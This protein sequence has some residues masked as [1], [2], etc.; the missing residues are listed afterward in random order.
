[1]FESLTSKGYQVEFTS[2]AEAILSVD[3]STA[4]ADLEKALLATT[5]PIEEII[6]SGGG[7]AKG[8]QRL[9]RV[10]TQMHWIKGTFTVQKVINGV[11]KESQSHIVDHVKTFEN[12]KTLALEIEWNNKDPFFDR[13]LE[14]Y[15]R[16]HADGAIS[17]G[18]IITRGQSLQD[19]MAEMVRRFVVERQVHDIA[20]MDEWGYS[21]TPKQR[22]RIMDAI[23]RARD[24][25][26]FRDAFA[27][28]FTSDKFGQ[29]TTHWRKLEDRIHRG[30]GNPCPMVYI[31]LPDSIVTFG[32]GKAALAEIEAGAAA[33]EASETP[34]D[35]GS[36]K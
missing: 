14:N 33:D 30:V 15:K 22:K 36:A 9:R 19:N 34:E 32:E 27:S 21:P 28:I 17:V 6:A 16:F 35:D 10:L 13:D 26:S 2:H 3:F 4:A 24:P 11:A 12:G 20:G 23:T 29:A 7:E 31:G 8:T 25:L 18:I 5:I 1:M